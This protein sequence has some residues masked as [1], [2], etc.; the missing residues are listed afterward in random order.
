MRKTLKPWPHL[1]TA[2]LWWTAGT[3]EGADLATLLQATAEAVVDQ[4]DALLQVPPEVRAA[5][6]PFVVAR[7][8]PRIELALYPVPVRDPSP[9]WSQWGDGLIGRD[10][11]FYSA[12]GDHGGPG[13][14]SYI[15]AYDPAA[16]R[17]DLVVDQQRLLGQSTGDWGFGKIHCRLE[18]LDDGLLYWGTYWGKAPPEGYVQSENFYGMVVRADPATGEGEVL[19]TV[20]EPLVIPTGMCDPRAKLFYALPCDRTWEGRGF[21]VF[22]LQKRKTIYY[23]HAE[24]EKGGRFILIDEPTGSAY[25]TVQ[26]EPHSPDLWLARYDAATN[27]VTLKEIPLPARWGPM[28]AG[29]EH[30]DPR[31]HYYAVS[32]GRIAHLDL[33]KKTAE[34]IGS[35]WGEGE[36]VT[37][38]EISPGGRYLYTIPRAHGTAWEI[39]APVVQYDLKTRT[40]KVLAFLGPYY[41]ERYGY[42]MGGS[43]CL[44]LSA[45]GAQLFFGMNGSGDLENRSGFGLPACGVLHIPASE[46]ADDSPGG[47]LPECT[48]LR[49]A[50]PIAVDGRLDEPSWQAA[51]VIDA[52]AFPWWEGGEKERTEARLLWD[53]RSLYIAF[54]AFDRHISASLTGRDAPVSQDDCVEVFAAPD[55][56]AVQNYFNFEFNALGTILDRSPHDGRSSAW[57]AGGMEVAIAAEGTLNDEADVDSLWTAEIA[58]PFSAFAGYAP[59]LPPRDGDLWRLNLYRTGG[60]VNLQYLAWSDTRTER[61][62]FHVPERFGIAHFASTRVGQ[63]R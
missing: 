8:P 21:L 60:Q 48:I 59:H 12:I 31:G 9:D 2:W 30:R 50:G 35:L 39:G 36:Y 53:D 7:T 56:G 63:E 15:Y 18:Q 10:G 22:D 23:G 38:V 14:R 42:L 49:A 45:D 24:E 54:V 26:P 16:H 51:P 6:F 4:S 13:A 1:L 52:F 44:A 41:R 25:F 11:R 5:A 47:D 46:R 58:I 43:Y 32:E 62:N 28:R 29:T 61:P 37:A 57:N 55:T 20:R 34:P 33:E 17:I 19:G 27:A 3:A 40:R